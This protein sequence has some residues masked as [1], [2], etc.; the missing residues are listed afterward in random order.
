MDDYARVPLEDEFSIQ[1]E[2]I[3]SSETFLISRGGSTSNNNHIIGNDQPVPLTRPPPKG[4]DKRYAFLFLLHFVAI[5]MFSTL[6]QQQSDNTSSSS[7]DT[8]LQRTRAGSWTSLA[9]ISTVLGSFFGVLVIFLLSNSSSRHF[10]LSSSLSVSIIIQVC[11]ANILFLFGA[12]LFLLGV[13]ALVSAYWFATYYRRARDSLNFT[14]AVIQFV[15]DISHDYG[16]SLAVSCASVVF[17]QT[18]LLLGWGAFL[19][20]LIASISLEYTSWLVLCMAVSFY[21]ITK[22]F[23]GMVAYI[24][25]GCIVWHFIRNENEIF[26]PKRRVLLHAQCALTT[27]FGSLC[28]GALLNGPSDF[29]SVLNLWTS[30]RRSTISPGMGGILARYCNCRRLVAALL[31]PIAEWCQ[32]NNRLAF[33]LTAI[34][35]QAFT[36]AGEQHILRY[37]SNA[38]LALTDISHY[39]LTCIAI[40]IAGFISIIFGLLN[41]SQNQEQYS[42]GTFVALIYFLSYSGLSLCMEIYK[43][44]VD[45][46]IVAYAIK[47][48]KLASENQ[49]IFLRFLRTSD[50]SL[51]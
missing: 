43:S 46:L 32:K 17:F 1:L 13:L 6:E 19:V 40:E 23:H 18:G 25:G 3:D 4:K 2:T 24:V 45:A 35:G 12:R 51:R 33:C 10:I 48:E 5:G 31:S 36:T 26:E 8:L 38:E 44:A 42:E 29:V 34:Y 50:P 30:G 28:K 27:S 39:N 14:S 21:W 49:I 22:L 7:H 9:M 20:N 16:S 47:P 41:F 11:L 37:P 15:G